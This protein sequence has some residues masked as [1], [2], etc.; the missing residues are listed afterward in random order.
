MRWALTQE[1]HGIFTRHRDGFERVAKTVYDLATFPLAYLDS[2]DRPQ[3]HTPSEF[4]KR[5]ALERAI[6]DNRMTLSEIEETYGTS[7][8]R[9][10]LSDL[11]REKL[12]L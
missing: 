11:G 2:R 7:L 3:Y 6:A 8:D 10:A 5:G 9:S 1:S 4:Q 12:D